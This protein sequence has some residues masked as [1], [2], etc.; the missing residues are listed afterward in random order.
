VA[1]FAAGWRTAGAG[2]T[3]LP[4][5]SLYAKANEPLWL[6]EVGVVNTTVTA[7]SMALRRA[8]TA[9]TQGAAQG[10]QYEE[11]NTVTVRGDPRDTHTVAPT[12]TAG[13]VR[14]GVIGASIGS[15]VIWT[16]GA[17]G[18]FIPAG[19]TNGVCL[20]PLAGAGQ[21]LDVY[22]SWDA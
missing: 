3:T 18:L 4:A 14:N 21:I 2:S 12:L 5:A 16:F 11:D 15:G 19:V 9:G 10:V 20:V 13:S 22:W 17:R 7:V 6:V 1:R 8:T